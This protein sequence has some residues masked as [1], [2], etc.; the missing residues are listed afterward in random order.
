MDRRRTHRNMKINLYKFDYSKFIYIREYIYR[1][2]KYLFVRVRFVRIKTKYIIQHIQ[3]SV[4][5]KDY[6]VNQSIFN[7]G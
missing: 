6:S 5:I 4:V 2:R 1:I 3:R 7:T